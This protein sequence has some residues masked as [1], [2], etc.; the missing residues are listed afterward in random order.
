MTEEE[1]WKLVR[2]KLSPGVEYDP[3]ALQAAVDRLMGREPV[4]KEEPKPPPEK[5]SPFVAHTY[6]LHE[7][8]FPDG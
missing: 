8:Y 7:K 3:D 1:A 4:K 6:G 5:P 2:S